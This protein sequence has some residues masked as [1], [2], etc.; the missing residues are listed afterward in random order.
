M[1]KDRRQLSYEE[2]NPENLAE[3]RRTEVV[4]EYWHNQWT[5]AAIARSQQRGEQVKL[6]QAVGEDQS[7]VPTACNPAKQPSRTGLGTRTAITPPTTMKAIDKKDI[8]AI[9]NP[10]SREVKPLSAIINTRKIT[11]PTSA[12]KEKAAPKTMSQ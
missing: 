12:I 11:I 10:P 3:G 8:M 7:P 1:D 4:G 9:A 6:H 5:Y 2:V